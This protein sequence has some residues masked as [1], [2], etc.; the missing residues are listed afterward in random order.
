MAWGTGYALLSVT[1]INIASKLFRGTYIMQI[2]VTGGAGFLGSHVADA[3]TEAGHYVTIFDIRTSPYLRS[4]QK[5]VTGDILDQRTLENITANQDVVYHFAGIADIDECAKRP[6]DTAK[7]N[8]IGTVRLL[9]ACRMA[10]VRRFIFASSAYVFSGSGYFYKSSKR[11][12]ESF[13][14]DFYQLYNLPYTC[15][16][17]GSL[18]GGRADERNSIYRMIRQAITEGK[19]TYSGQGDEVR[20]FIHVRDAA[21]SSVRV[22][23]P[24]FEN[25]NI[26]LTGTEKLTYRQLLEMIREIM[27]NKIDIDFVTS[28][29]KAHYK[30][31]P[32]NFSPKLGRKLINNPHVDMGQGLLLCMTEIYEKVHSE[33]H[34]EMGL[35]T[36][37]K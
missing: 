31:T 26:I 4:G 17:Y 37:E 5:M 11:A 6:V 36:D 19:I 20:E 29:R 24:E 12:C 25:Q 14:E 8:I 34:E 33:K 28:T 7:Y 9:E 16:R 2:L 23:E 1:I 3:L 21:Q 13:I 35:L 32:Y 10:G 15:L 30:L 18:Y 22:L 27:G